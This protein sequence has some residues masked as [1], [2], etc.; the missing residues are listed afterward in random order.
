MSKLVVEYSEVIEKFVDVE[1]EGA[2]GIIVTA[3][4]TALKGAIRGAAAVS[5]GVTLEITSL[6]PV[7]GEEG[8]LEEQRVVFSVERWEDI[9]RMGDAAIEAYHKKFSA[10]S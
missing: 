3:A 4:S 9:K 1:I 10:P 5:P 2:D 7:E 8:E 6:G